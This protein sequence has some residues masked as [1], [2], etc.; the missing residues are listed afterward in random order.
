MKLEYFY[1]AVKIS[2]IG[3]ISKAAKSLHI[4]QPYLSASLKR[5]ED[6]LEIKLFHRTNKGVEPTKAGREFID[7][8]N[9]V[10]QLVSKVNTLEDRYSP[11]SKR[12]AIVSMPSYTMLYLLN[13]FKNI[14]LE[15]Y[16]SSSIS[17]K[18]VPNTFI[19]EIVMKNEADI[20]I[21]Y[22]ISTEHELRLKQFEEMNLKFVPLVK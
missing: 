1:Y 20:G 19:A 12:F 21:I 4:S 9:Q 3:S 18:E 13:N 8:S 17:Y 14:A 22:T 6:I 16:S 15:K 2:K 10:I 7:Y 5:L 11:Q